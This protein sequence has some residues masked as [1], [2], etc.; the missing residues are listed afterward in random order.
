MTRDPRQQLESDITSE[1]LADEMLHNGSE[2]GA[3][4]AED[5]DVA[6]ENAVITEAGSGIVAV[7]D[8]VDDLKRV[9]AA[10]LS[11]DTTQHYHVPL[12]VSPWSYS[13]YRGS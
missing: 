4:E 1:E 10:E 6:D 13:T 2:E 8:T 5:D 11:T 3:E 9:L 7:V 12:L